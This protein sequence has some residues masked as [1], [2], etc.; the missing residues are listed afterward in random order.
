MN[1]T[2]FCLAMSSGIGST[3]TGGIQDIAGFLP[4]LGTEQCYPCELG[5][6]T[7]ISLCCISSYANIREPRGSEC[8]IPDIAC[9]L[10]IWRY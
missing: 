3:L 1:Q 8:W 9:L 10:L 7:R 5:A 2:S 6:H 4:L